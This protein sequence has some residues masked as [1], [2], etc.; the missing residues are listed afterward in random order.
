MVIRRP[1]K[2]D[3]SLFSDIEKGDDPQYAINAELNSTNG[4]SP[5]VFNQ[6]KLNT[7]YLNQK[8]PKKIQIQQNQ[9]K[10]AN[11][12]NTCNHYTPKT[13][14]DVKYFPENESP[15]TKST[16]INRLRGTVGLKKSSAYSINLKKL[17]S[18]KNQKVSPADDTDESKDELKLPKATSINNNKIVESDDSQ[19]SYSIAGSSSPIEIKKE[20]ISPIPN[21]F[22]SSE[23][24][25][26]PS[27]HDIMAE[28]ARLGKISEKEFID[29]VY[30]L[31][32]APQGKNLTGMNLGSDPPDQSSSDIEI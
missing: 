26:T 13:S 23:G 31:N 22:E 14:G 30:K 8:T 2:R 10:N 3:R 11:I 27:E 28:N 29:Y 1:V 18:D 32:C 15:G 24:N 19:D 21:T 12:N 16:A 17:A 9:Q 5:S 4:N 20:Y 6:S 7:Q 25:N